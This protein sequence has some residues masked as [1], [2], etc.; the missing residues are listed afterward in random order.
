[1]A[2]QTDARPEEQA[3]AS[4]NMGSSAC[5]ICSEP[6]NEG[7]DCLFINQCSH[8]FHRECIESHL[9]AS[10]RC[11]VCQ[12]PCQLN[13]LRTYV[14]TPKRQQPMSKQAKRG[15][16]RGAMARSYNTRSASRNLFQD[17]A[18]AGN[19]QSD[20][21]QISNQNN[22]SPNN[23]PFVLS[24]FD[25]NTSQPSANLGIDYGEINR[26]IEINIT[27]ILQNLNLSQNP[28]K[29]TTNPI[30]QPGNDFRAENEFPNSSIPRG[31]VGNTSN[32]NVT[33]NPNL[34][35]N[36]HNNVNGNAA[37]GSQCPVNSNFPSNSF[38]I[39]NI[40]ADKVTSIINNWG[41]KFD[42]S[43]SGL[44]IDEFLYRVTTLTNE[45]FDSD[46][47]VICK[48]LNILLAGKAREWY[49]RYHKL[50]QSITWE[51]FCK[52]I[53][54]QYK[55]MKSSFDLREEIR[56]RKQKPGETY[57]AFF[58]ALSSIADRLPR[59]MIE[60]EFIEIIARNLR[61]EIRQDLLYVPIYSLS[62]LRKLVQMR[63]NFL[64]DEY[65]RKTLANRNVNSNTF[66]RRM[67][68][69]LDEQ[70]NVDNSEPEFSIEAI[71][72][73]ESNCNCWNCGNS[74][75]HWQD[76]LETRTI[77]CYGCG[78]KNVYKPQCIKCIGRRSK[79]LIPMGPQ[80]DQV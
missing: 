63:E 74:G 67:V 68:A 2:E 50:V 28:T 26:L 56:N 23:G 38:A 7:Q 66:P 48:N 64:N 1:M 79:N 51:E 60:E 10:S 22:V 62:H 24:P 3:L 37:Q 76:C 36:I 55:E 65:V 41:L 43:S 18:T 8:Y 58:D 35:G 47:R 57:D 12:H 77:F 11:P 13:E 49:W 15:K 29:T 30:N 61:P 5:Q 16:G 39:T 52:A 69:E 21:Q 75:H 25:N 59:P 46:F 45:N 19:F 32:A 71:N 53:R 20:Q 6:L 9:S 34:L 17:M 70:E 4:T 31:N 40:H 73:N 14:V 33:I 80:K 72:K 78:T 44:T 42:G 54:G 27:R